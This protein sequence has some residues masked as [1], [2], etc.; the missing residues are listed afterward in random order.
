MHTAPNALIQSLVDGQRRE[1][2]SKIGGVE[3]DYFTLEIIVK[4]TQKWLFVLVGLLLIPLVLAIG[5][6]LAIEYWVPGEV[7]REVWSKIA[8]AIFCLAIP[9]LFFVTYKSSVSRWIRWTAAAFGL[10]VYAAGIYYSDSVA[11]ARCGT[12]LGDKI[13]YQKLPAARIASC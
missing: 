6:Q 2:R 10:L 8:I 7:R 13:Q 1:R 12:Y 4:S 5:S 9:V 11:R 3:Y